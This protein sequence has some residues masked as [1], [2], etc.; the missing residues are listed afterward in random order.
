MF[1]QIPPRQKS[2]PQRLAFGNMSVPGTKAGAVVSIGLVVVAWLASWLGAFLASSVSKPGVSCTMTRNSAPV[3]AGGSLGKCLSSR[4]G[5]ERLTKHSMIG[6][7][8]LGSNSQE[9][10][11]CTAG[12]LLSCQSRMRVLA[13]LVSIPTRCVHDSQPSRADAAN[14]GVG[15]HRS[16][17]GRHRRRFDWRAFERVAVR[18]D[19]RRRELDPHRLAH[20]YSGRL[21]PARVQGYASAAC[22]ATW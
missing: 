16:A 2:Q 3:V 12:L 6:E 22:W 15:L 19:S 4:R 14:C 1:E 21:D 13:S 18:R 9:F 7:D 20:E 8:A 10:R 5:M 11:L 17:G